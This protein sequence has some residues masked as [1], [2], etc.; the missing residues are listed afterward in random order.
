M[1]SEDTMDGENKEILYSDFSSLGSVMSS[2]MQS[3]N[4]KQGVKKA[5]V[6]KFWSKV[7]GKKFEKYS[8]PESI[9]PSN[10]LMI[11]CANAAVSSELMMFKPEILK[12]IN[13]Y[14]KPLGVIIED[15]NFSHKI[16]RTQ[17]STEQKVYQEP[18]NPYKKDLTGFDPDKVELN[19][20]DVEAIK[21]SVDNNKFAT[22]EQRKKMFDAII[23]DLKIQKFDNDRKSL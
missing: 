15:I 6:F 14:S 4:L 19:P 13:T 11:A 12:K 3:S 22:E 21:K 16:W 9:T 10:V 23:L 8:R 7:V 5:S 17:I 18:K 1:Y 2:V 20:D